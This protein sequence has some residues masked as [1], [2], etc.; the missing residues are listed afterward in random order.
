MKFDN[1]DKCFEKLK[2]LSLDGS[3]SLIKEDL[4]Q[5]GI[6]HD[7]FFSETELIEKDLVKKFENKLQKK[8]KFVE[9]GYLSPPK[10][11]NPKSWKKIKRL[12][13]KS[14]TFGDDTDRALQNDGSWT[15]FANDVAYHSDKII[16]RKFSNLINVLG[17]DHTGYIKRISA[18]VSALSDEKVNFTCKVCQLVKTLIKLANHSK[19][20]KEQGNLF[21][22]KTY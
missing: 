6:N 11:S 20:L 3:M 2:K 13:F 16:N 9:E 17:A 12:I 19:C 1:F 15:Y 14:T 8:K 7:S 21:L 18:A 5:L 10:G 4:K 22:L